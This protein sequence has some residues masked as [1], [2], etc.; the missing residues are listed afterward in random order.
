MSRA[1]EFVGFIFLGFGITAVAFFGGVFVGYLIGYEFITSDLSDA[2]AKIPECE[3]YAPVSFRVE[4]PDKDALDDYEHVYVEKGWN[5]TKTEV[6]PGYYAAFS[7]S[8][9]CQEARR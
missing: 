4:V 6:S 1:L 5:V 9:T 7:M 3:P 8:A 2:R